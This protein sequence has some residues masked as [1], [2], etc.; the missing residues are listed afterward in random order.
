MVF[1]HTHPSR[2]RP[3][4]QAM[5]C[6]GHLQ[7]HAVQC[8]RLAARTYPFALV[9]LVGKASPF[10]GLQ[11]QRLWAQLV[12]VCQQAQCVHG[13]PLGAVHAVKLPQGLRGDIVH[14][15]QLHQRAFVGVVVQHPG[16]EL[17]LFAQLAVVQGL[18]LLHQA[19]LQQQS[20]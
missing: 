14:T 7:A 19:R 11:S 2:V 17:A 5:R 3:G 18:K 12:G 9:D 8:C 6:Q 4:L 1:A 15:D 13:L 16:A 10:S 20:A